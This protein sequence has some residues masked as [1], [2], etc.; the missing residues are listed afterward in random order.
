VKAVY[1]S[2][3]GSEVS[4]LVVRAT[5]DLVKRIPRFNSRL[6]T[7]PKL[8]LTVTVR[9]EAW[10][11]DS[12]EKSDLMEFTER[13]IEDGIERVSMHSHVDEFQTVI[14]EDQHP[15][16]EIREAIG[17]E[18]IQ[19]RR[20]DN[21]QIVDAN[22]LPAGENLSNIVKEGDESPLGRHGGRVIEQA[23]MTDRA[24]AGTLKEA[25]PLKGEGQAHFRIRNP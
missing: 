21:G 2:L 10:E 25:Q 14:D 15:P 19:P 24:K 9:V 18:G 7:F 12:I 16:D 22:P 23:P 6:V 17:V 11:R 1:E 3:T 13:V 5:A 20:L 4:K 8:K